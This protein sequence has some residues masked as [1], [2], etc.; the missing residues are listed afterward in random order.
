VGQR[1]AAA[2]ED[3]ARWVDPEMSVHRRCCYDIPLSTRSRGGRHRIA[4]LHGE[5]PHRVQT[6]VIDRQSSYPASIVRASCGHTA[7]IETSLGRE[8]FG[9]RRNQMNNL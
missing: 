3:D 4:T 7:A 8:G 6:G 5:P 2:I 1:P 9:R